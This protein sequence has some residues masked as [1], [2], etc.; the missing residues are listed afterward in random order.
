[1]ILK[2]IQNLGFSQTWKHSLVYN[3][4]QIKTF[5]WKLCFLDLSHVV[6]KVRRYFVMYFQ[7]IMILITI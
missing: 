5:D 3:I 2:V 7:G 4:Q 6:I 1:M